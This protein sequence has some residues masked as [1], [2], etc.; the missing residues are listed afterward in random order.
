MSIEVLKQALE[1]LKDVGVLTDREWQAVHKN[2]ANELRQAIAELESQKPVAWMHI[3]DNT[4]GIKANGAGIVSIT[5]KRKHP[6]GKA[7]IDF[8]KSYPVT[9]TPLYTH[10]PQRTEKEPVA[11]IEG[12]PKA[13]YAEEWFIAK[14]NDGD[15]V[16]LQA[17]PEE[18]KHDFTTRD[19]TYFLKESIKSWMQFPDTEFLPPPQRPWVGLTDEEIRER[20]FAAEPTPDGRS[21]SYNYARAIEAKL[22]QKNGYAEEKNT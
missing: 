12:Y 3:M 19:G 7:G 2:K 21:A 6:F 13:H 11:W 18:F 8:S 17:L 5:Q 14:L 1:A 10:P 16:V 22:K 15:R 20:W 4:E 9:S